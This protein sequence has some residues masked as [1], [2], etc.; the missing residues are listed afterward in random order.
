MGPGGG[1]GPCSTRNLPQDV[2]AG[3]DG[4][5]PRPGRGAAVEG[6]FS[7]S[8]ALRALQALRASRGLRRRSPMP[9]TV[10]PPDRPFR[11][12]WIVSVAV[13]AVTLS[14]LSCLSV[15]A[16]PPGNDP[17]A[18]PTSGPVNV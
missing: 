5:C 18:R 13:G 1:G 9:D 7:G 6:Y 4:G 8:R 17:V 15:R 14:A 11:R 16:A 2:P 12:A 10:S 3:R